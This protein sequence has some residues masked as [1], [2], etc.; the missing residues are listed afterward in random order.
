MEIRKNTI[1]IMKKIFFGVAAFA[2]IALAS[3]SSKSD[4]N[5]DSAVADSDTIVAAEEVTEVAVDSINP[6]SANVAVQQ[7]GAVT[8]EVVP[9]TQSNAN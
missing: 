4:S 8:E 2:M 9:A 1:Q 7:V 3:C 5:A 6:D